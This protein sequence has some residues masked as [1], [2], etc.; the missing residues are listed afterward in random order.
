M[1]SPEREGGEM[2]GLLWWSWVRAAPHQ[3][4]LME[5]GKLALTLGLLAIVPGHYS[6]CL[7]YLALSVLSTRCD[8][9]RHGRPNNNGRLIGRAPASLTRVVCV[10]HHASAAADFYR[11]LIENAFRSWPVVCARL[12]GVGTMGTSLF[13]PS[14]SPVSARKWDWR[15]SVARDRTSRLWRSAF[16]ELNAA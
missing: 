13:V 5:G 4:H 2:K 9:V 1:W 10:A 8:N 15:E 14:P 12:I 7:L 6:C 16:S 11:G 3:H